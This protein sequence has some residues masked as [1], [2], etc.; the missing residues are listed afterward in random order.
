MAD[1]VYVDTAGIRALAADMM[2][3]VEGVDLVVRTDMAYHAGRLA[4]HAGEIKDQ[5]PGK[6]TG[7]GSARSQITVRAEYETKRQ[8]RIKASGHPLA[9]LWEMGNTRSREN[10]TTFRHPVFGRANSWEDQS[11]W[12]YLRMAV[13]RYGPTIELELGDAVVH[14][15]EVWIARAPGARSNVGRSTAGTFIPVGPYT[16]TSS[17]PGGP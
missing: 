7:D 5:Y 15:V 2:R 10:D 4:Q 16:V 12:P 8:W 6:G 11:K 9:G 3:A 14:E 1:A 17:A 13:D